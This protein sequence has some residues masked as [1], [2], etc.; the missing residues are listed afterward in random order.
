MG[1]GRR[2]YNYILPGNLWIYYCYVPIYSYTYQHS[3]YSEYNSDINIYT[4]V[5]KECSLTAHAHLTIY[6]HFTHF[7][8]ILFHANVCKYNKENEKQPKRGYSNF[9]SPCLVS[10]LIYPLLFS[11]FLSRASGPLCSQAQGPQE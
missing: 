2:L 10:L 5:I 7:I 9:L 6:T 11:L 8:T 1:G 3:S 4:H